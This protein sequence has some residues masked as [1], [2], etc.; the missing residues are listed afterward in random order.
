[1]SEIKK[2][3]KDLIIENDNLKNS[4][5]NLKTNIINMKN[6]IDNNNF[7]PNKLDIIGESLG[8]LNFLMCCLILLGAVNLV[9]TIYLDSS[10]EIIINLNDS[11]NNRNVIINELEIDKAL[12]LLTDWGKLKEFCI[13]KYDSNYWGFYS[14]GSVYCHDKTSR[15]IIRY[16]YNTMEYI[17]FSNGN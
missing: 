4:I 5:K 7:I 10:Q 2:I 16:K 14:L 6:K 15:D 11:N 1:M 3:N 17:K 13:N 9:H 8:I 12:K